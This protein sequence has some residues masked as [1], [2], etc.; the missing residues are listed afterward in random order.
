MPSVFHW[1]ILIMICVSFLFP[2]TFPI[3]LR[4]FIMIKQVCSIWYN[5]SA[6]FSTDCSVYLPSWCLYLKELL[7]R[8]V[9][10]PSGSSKHLDPIC[11]HQSIFGIGEK[12]LFNNIS[13]VIIHTLS[14]TACSPNHQLES[15]IQ[16]LTI[17][18]LTKL[19]FVKSYLSEL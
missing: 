4:S 10:F 17:A 7:R 5:N 2:I 1:F 14:L 12:T 9:T 8:L 19:L 6:S 16:N 13:S 15:L 18:W 3:S 11:T